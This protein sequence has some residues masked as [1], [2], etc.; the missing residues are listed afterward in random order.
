MSLLGAE[1][2]EGGTAVAM[3]SAL[4]SGHLLEGVMTTITLTLILANR[5]S[6]TAN[7]CSGPQPMARWVGGISIVSVAGVASFNVVETF[8]G[9]FGPG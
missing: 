6:P 4:T 2:C 5:R 3:P 8:L 1:R 7:R 9:F